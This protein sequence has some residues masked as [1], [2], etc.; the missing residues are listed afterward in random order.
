MSTLKTLLAD[1]ARA[2]VYQVGPGTQ[3]IEAA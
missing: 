2:G 3:S 1:K